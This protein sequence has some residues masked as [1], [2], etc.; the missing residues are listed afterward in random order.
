[1]K[2]LL[3]DD[4]WKRLRKSVENSERYGSGMENY[5]EDVVIAL[6]EALGDG[7]REE[8]YE[9]AELLVS[10]ASRLRDARYDESFG[11]EA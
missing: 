8:R 3:D 4:F 1:M 9:A 11:L 2:T 10:A 6:A 5:A 7:D